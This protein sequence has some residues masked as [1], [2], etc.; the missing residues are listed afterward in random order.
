[1]SGVVTLHQ[2]GTFAPDSTYR[3]MS[4]A[5]LDKSKDIAIGYSASSSTIHSATR[6][7]GRVPTDPGTQT[8][9]RK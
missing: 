8:S 2:Q 5:A 9:T 6:F 4:S 7:T 3:W 1:M